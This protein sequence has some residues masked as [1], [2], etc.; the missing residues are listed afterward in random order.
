MNYATLFDWNYIRKGMVLLKSMERHI[1]DY[2]AYVLALDNQ[3]WRWMVA[4]LPKNTT[5]AL[6][7]PLVEGKLE[8]A[9]DNRTWTEFCWSLASFWTFRCMQIQNLD[10]LTYVDADCLFL[11]DPQPVFDEIGNAPFAIPPHRF[12]EQDKARLSPNGTYNV[13]FVYFSR[14][15]L[16]CLREWSDYCL[17]WCY[18]KNENGNFGDQGI[19]DTL[20]PKHNG[21]A[22][23]HPGLNC[24][25]W[26][27]IQYKFRQAPGGWRISELPLILYHFHELT[28]DEQGI[29]TRTTGWPLNPDILPLYNQYQKELLN[30]QLVS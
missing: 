11:S 17:D 3:T 28:I 21:H 12:A 18:Y 9:K 5:V 20:V 10:N 24:A 29:I 22:I 25:P 7:K 13:N 4:H 30:V 6:L 2:H 26:N 14:R 23:E 16:A 1:P 8:Q 19:F 27:Q 15:G